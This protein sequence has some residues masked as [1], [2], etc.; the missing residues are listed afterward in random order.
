LNQHNRFM[1]LGMVAL[2]PLWIIGMGASPFSC[3]GS[4]S[5][6]SAVTPSPSQTPSAPVALTASNLVGTWQSSC[7]PLTPSVGG[8]EIAT[9]YYEITFNSNN[10]YSFADV[11]YVA[12][13]TSSGHGAG[14][15]CWGA[16]NVG[17]LSSTGGFTMGSLITSSSPLTAIQF[18]PSASQIRPE[19]AATT[20][21]L[22]NSGCTGLGV[23]FVSGNYATTSNV[24][25]QFS[26]QGG[27]NILVDNIVEISGTT[28]GST[29]T[30]GAPSAALSML[31]VVH[32]NTVPTTATVTLIKQ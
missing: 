32:G 1:K 27:T 11:W 21:W 14:S 4:S 17:D 22:N 29:M 24:N 2:A 25:C 26:L 28:T 13:G 18:A 16:A 19:D 3:Q 6:N 7:M 9:H 30:F 10:T 8:S 15:G 31:G 12:G 20:T 23:T 5:S